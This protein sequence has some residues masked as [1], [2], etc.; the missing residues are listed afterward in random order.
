M[1][2]L[3]DDPSAAEIA[4]A[5]ED[6]RRDVRYVVTDFVAELVVAKFGRDEGIDGPFDIY[7]PEYQRKLAWTDDQKSYFIESM[8]LRVP[9]SP[10]Y[11][12]EVEGRLEIVDGS[13][14]IRT[15]AGFVRD[16]F[17]LQNLEKLDVLNG[18]RFSELPSAV[19]RRFQNT[20][21]RGF[22]LDQGTDEAVR[23]DLFRR[24]NT[25]GK[26][27]ADAEVRKGAYRGPF[28]DLVVDSAASQ[29]FRA[30]APRM[31][32]VGDEESERQELATRF[33]VYL[34]AYEDF[35]HD[36]RDFLDAHTRRLNAELDPSRVAEMRREFEEV[37]RFVA[38]S[39][40]DGFYRRGSKNRVPRVR[41][42]AI[43]IGSA[44]ALRKKSDLE[45]G[46]TAWI[47]SEEFEKLTRT[48]AS[49]SGPRLRGR[50]EYVRDALL[51]GRG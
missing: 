38:R 31:G 24:L 27:L 36:V 26:R 8:L 51:A 40:D 47:Q 46:D 33:Y 20:P 23:I 10:V 49:N 34:E 45:A 11:F 14:R 43:A 17:T 28:L 9:I 15:L 44:L 41:F 29:A 18:L 6:E 2:K 19:R 7:V 32:G 3:F 48:D 35:R 39:F 42:E 21:I 5:V 13:Q 1:P 4:A 22:V 25:S 12:Y 16:E 30:A 37:M 50:I